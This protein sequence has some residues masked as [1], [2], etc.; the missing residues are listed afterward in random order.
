M[1]TCKVCNKDFEDI[2][3]VFRHLRAHKLKAQEYVLVWSYGN[4]PPLCL[5]G[6]GRNTSWN[7]SLRNYTTFIKGHSA[8]GRTKSEDEKR[9]IGE[10]NRVNM[11]AW[12]AR[13]PDIA[14]KK[15]VQMTEART[16]EIE[17]R[18]L[19]STR[20]TY[21]SM[22]PEDKQ[23]FSDHT[24]EL[25]K[26]GT[27]VVA[28]KK[29]TETY[30]QR[31]ASGEYDFTERNDKISA[32]VTQ[33]YLDG[34]FEWSTGQYISSRTGILCNYRSSWERELMEILDADERVES[35][36]YEPISIPYVLDG[37]SRR[38]VP[39]FHVVTKSGTD[40][41]IEVKPPSLSNTEMNSCKRDAAIEFCSRNCWRYFEWS[42]G[43]ELPFTA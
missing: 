25:W 6:C 36:R 11:K 37:K 26:D 34:G 9:R 21:A 40:L 20:K 3:A 14:K 27:L 8:K 17:E 41:M 22:T 24:K 42:R 30:K 1:E 12:M 7:V 28:R 2:E 35:W 15:C 13:H 10:K 38:Y 18:R 19:E 39:D 33:R 5:C 4:V 16:P 43:L 31:Y 29:A 32:T 23:K